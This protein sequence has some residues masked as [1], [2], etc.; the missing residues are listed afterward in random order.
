MI[1]NVLAIAG[2]DPSGG[3]GIQADLKSIQACGGYGMAALT[4]LTAQSTQ[5]VSGVHVPPVGFLR[6]QLDALASDIR[7]DAVKI[8]MLP[9]SAVIDE[10]VSWIDALPAKPP[11]V[12]DPVMVA[13][14][15]DRLIDPDAV[16][17]LERLIA[18]ADVVTPNLPELAALLGE[19][20]ASSWPF[21]R[22]QAA[23][24]AQRHGVLVL[25]KGGHLPG[26]ETP[27]AL[28]GVDGAVAQFLGAR[29]A[30]TSTH[31]T[32]CSLSSALAAIYARSGDWVVAARLARAWLRGAIAAASDLEVGAPGGHGP[33]HHAYALWAGQAFPGAGAEL[34]TW[35]DDVEPIRSAI[36]DLWFVRQLADGTLAPEDFEN[37]LAQD[38]LYL[39]C[40][41][42]ALERAAELAP[43][44]PE[45]EFWARGAQACRESELALHEA[46]VGAVVGADDEPEPS[47]E[48]ISYLSHLAASAGTGDYGI[49]TA[50]IL[51]C[52]WV[53]QDVG[54]KLARVNHPGHPYADWL[55]MYGSPE[56]AASTRQAIAWVQ[57]AVRTATPDQLGRMREA[58]EQSCRHELAFFAQR[59][60]VPVA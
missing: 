7:I 22:E 17:A 1:P 4:A 23:R 19:P 3:A 53:Y 42:R 35:W 57:R 50:A 46:R 31:G 37:Y 30:T 25:A 8:G 36:D 60:A 29:I 58:F 32:G 12:L 6:Q 43:T 34:T 47:E 40:Y 20:V 5:G 11:I 13:S 16:I 51:P 52:Y 21:A 54:E 55:T 45:R 2:S 41:A 18:H 27:D 15:G 9:S 49:L 38:A 39:H 59:A 14:S 26:E 28:I 56:F 44:E 24:L 33:L 48:T 10:V